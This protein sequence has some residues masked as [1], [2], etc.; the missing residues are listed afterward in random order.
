VIE[1]MGLTHLFAINSIL[2]T[3]SMDYTILPLVVASW[4]QYTILIGLPWL[5]YEC[6]IG[7]VRL[8]RDLLSTVTWSAIYCHVICLY[9]LS[10]DLLPS[11]KWSVIYCHVICYLLSPDLL[12]TVTWSV[13]IYYHEIC[14]LLS[15]NLLYTVK[16]SGIYCQVICDLRRRKLW[17][18]VMNCYINL[19]E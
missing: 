9:L 15:R 2:C 11:V 17:C 10:W 13:Y 5:D 3:F 16:W 19:A 1:Q 6:K 18:P 12:S 8:S 4:S 7:Y 14:Y